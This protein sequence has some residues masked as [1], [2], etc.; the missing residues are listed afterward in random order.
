MNQE[1]D[2]ARTMIKKLHEHG[3]NDD[4]RY[5]GPLSYQDFQIF[6]W[7]CIAAA[8]AALMISL[9]MKASPDMEKRLSRAGAF[10]DDISYLSVPLMLIANFARILNNS[11][12]YGP[13][14][15]RN[16]MALLGVFVVFNVGFNHFI[17]GS[18]RMVSAEPDQVM[19]LLKQIFQKLQKYDYAAFNVFVDLFLCTLFMFFLNYRPK[20]IFVG[21][22]LILFRLFAILP[23]AYETASML[24]RIACTTDK[25]ELPV[26]SFAL[27]SVKPP[28]SF[29]VFLLM[30]VFMKIREWRYSRNGNTYEDYEAFLRT[31]RNSWHFSLSMAVFML[32]AGFVD[33]FLLEYIMDTVE[34][35]SRMPVG[36]AIGIGDSYYLVFIAPFMLLLSY[37]RP[38]RIG[39]NDILIPVASIALILFIVFQGIYQILSVLN[40]PPI[41]FQELKTWLEEF[42]GIITAR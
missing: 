41:D 15:L 11:E 14:L 12:G 19:P 8:V 38:P 6:G 21:K 27:L 13:Q 10:M 40:I 42:A 22:R 24:L 36:I 20:R 28:I 4:I 23:V 37:T 25:V 34:A 33:Y 16:G 26:W 7:L 29:I 9:G 1:K 39:K 35:A 31:N 2:K 30:V 32:A 3:C 17:A 18:L 5:R